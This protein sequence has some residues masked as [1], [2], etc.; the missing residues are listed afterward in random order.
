MHVYDNT[1]TPKRIIRKHKED[2]SIYSKCD[3]EI[4]QNKNCP[5]CGTY[6]E[7]HGDEPVRQCS[8]YGK[9]DFNLCDFLSKAVLVLGC[10]SSVYFAYTCGVDRKIYTCE[11]NIFL[12]IILVLL[13]RVGTVVMYAILSTLGDIKDRLDRLE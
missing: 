13:G 2:I 11:R 3:K 10:I 9:S 4:G 1:E 8:K 12:T 5:F 7:V 6:N